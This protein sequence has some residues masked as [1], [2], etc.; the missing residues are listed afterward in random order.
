VIDPRTNTQKLLTLH[1]DAELFDA[2]E[3]CRGRASRS[4]WIRQ[5]IAEKVVRE[6]IKL[7][8]DAVFAPDRSGKGGRPKNKSTKPPTK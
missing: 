7:S 8:E 3:R 2:A 6:G 1:V 4:Q 5:A